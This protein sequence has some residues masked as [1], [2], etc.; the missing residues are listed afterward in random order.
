MT[1]AKRPKGAHLV[2]TVP[3]PDATEVFRLVCG[4]LG[5][6]LKRVT[7]GETGER[8][9]WIACQIRVLR[10]T[11]AFEMVPPP[12]G[13]FDFSGYKFEFPRA[14][15]RKGVK[16]KDIKF[17]SLGYAEAAQKSYEA[18]RA[19]RAEGVIPEGVRMQMDLPTPLAPVS[20]FVMEN[21]WETVEPA[22]EAALLRELDEILESIPHEDLALQWDTAVEFS[23][24]EGYVG[25]FDDP[26]TEIFGRVERLGN[27]VPAD[28]ELGYHLC[29]GEAGHKHFKEPE[30][31]GKLVAMANGIAERL[32]RPLHWIHMPA[33]R[34]RDDEAY[35][36]PLKGLRV[37]PETELY[38]G[39]V[40]MTGGVE[41]IQRR[42]AAAQT[43]VQDFGV[44]TEC[45][46]N[47]RPVDTI[48]ELLR[49]H[50]EVADPVR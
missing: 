19:L 3:L 41:G 22:Y 6:H 37:H 47:Q 28:V 18:F 34:N 49:R 15:L 2:G 1:T 50:A 16:A 35:F 46:W 44:A 11:P 42:I 14:G 20:V 32:R 9:H 31:T 12:P 29:Y 17:G 33:P 27:T 25:R 8:N 36:A 45:G 39:V 38:L 4:T 30:D 48:P 5:N 24:L 21:D 43:A 13:G 26:W 40:H 10:E 23:H 7:D